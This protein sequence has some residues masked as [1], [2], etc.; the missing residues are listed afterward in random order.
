MMQIEVSGYTTLA[1]TGGHSAAIF[2]S[3]WA[4][5]QKR[6]FLPAT[7]ERLRSHTHYFWS[8]ERRVPHS[9]EDSNYRLAAEALLQPAEFENVHPAPVQAPPEVCARD[10]ARLIQRLTPAQNGVPRLDLILLGLGDDGHA[11]SLFPTTDVLADNQLLVR[12]VSGDPAHPH[13]RLTFTPALIN[14]AQSVW[15]LVLGESKQRAIRALFERRASLSEI[16]ALAVDPEQT[17]V[18]CFLDLPA[19]GELAGEISSDK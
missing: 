3:A 12:A 17:E 7:R 13:D 4:E 14:A 11:A 18:R 9:S 19:A 5:A 2:Y 16:P 15:F 10:Y 1:L 8:D 6:R